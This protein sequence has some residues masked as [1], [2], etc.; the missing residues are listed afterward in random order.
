MF[1]PLAP[2]RERLAVGALLVLYLA[3]AIG[4]AL[5][6]PY[7]EAPDEQSHFRY[8]EYLVRY[9]S[10]PPIEAR[11]YTNEAEQP[12]L[13][14]ALG[15]LLAQAGLLLGAPRDAAS[16]GLTPR[17]PQNP[18]LNIPGAV[19]YTVVQHPPG[20]RWPFWPYALRGLSILLGLGS[21]LL[22]Y[23]IART[24]LP[25]PAPGAAALVATAFA[26]LIPQADFIRASVSNGNLT[27]LLGAWITLLLVQHIMQQY[28][29]RRVLWLGVAGGLALLTKLT[30]APFGLLIGL[31]LA[32][33]GGAS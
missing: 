11:G 6:T 7:G 26:A 22:T 18:Q 20:Q 15:A 24:L 31:V 29:T 10:L 2:R 23:R 3:T 17:L 32:L 16:G 33:R 30:L 4:F 28:R 19:P 21:V 5:A 13:Y 12:P 14:Y 27:D 25:P 8:V 1:D 9:G